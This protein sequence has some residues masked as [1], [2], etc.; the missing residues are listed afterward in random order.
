MLRFAAVM[1]FLVASFT[2]LA[3][4]ALGG[5]LTIAGTLTASDPVYPNGRP[6]D[7]DCDARIDD[8]LPGK[9]IYHTYAIEVTQSGTYSYVD[10]GHFDA[11]V[12]TIDIE[13]A[14]YD[15][16]FSPDKPVKNCV[17][18]MDDDTTVKL[19]AGQTYLLAV[20]AYDIPI[21]GNYSFTITGPGDVEVDG[22][23]L[24]TPAP[25]ACVY[26]LPENAI[27]YSIPSRAPAYYEA[28]EASRLNFDLPAGAWWIIQT[29]GD[30]SQVWIAC[31]AQ[32][33]WV[34]TTSI[35]P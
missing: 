29:V 3:V 9:Y 5:T 6:D 19:V 32:P 28:D 31:P 8:V 26:P 1:L 2:I 21:T 34:P 33:V 23:V 22:G 25:E 16:A 17:T 10:N 35:V 14:V 11:D 20:T 30:F 7:S 12:S 15:G 4:P 13:V 27:V 18:S 24:A